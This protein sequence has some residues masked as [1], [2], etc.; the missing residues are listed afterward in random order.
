MTMAV[1]NTEMLN[2]AML[3]YNFRV[4]CIACLKKQLVIWELQTI[5]L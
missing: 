5:P 1:H 2:I 4:L 3:F